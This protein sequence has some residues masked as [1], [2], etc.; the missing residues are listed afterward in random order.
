MNA[1]EEILYRKIP[2]HRPCDLTTNLIFGRKA[3]L[4]DLW[5]RTAKSNSYFFHFRFCD[6][7]F[8]K[9]SRRVDNRPK[10]FPAHL[11]PA[12]SSWIIYSQNYTSSRQISLTLDGLIFVRQLIGSTNLKLSIISECENTCHQEHSVKLQEN[13]GFLFHSGIWDFSYSPNTEVGNTSIV[14]LTETILS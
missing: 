13:E 7:E 12:Y 8:L 4:Q 3:T 10:F 1:F 11:P 14:F 5:K 9:Q 2:N 6:P